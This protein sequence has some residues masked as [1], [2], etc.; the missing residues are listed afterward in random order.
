M[1]G[2]P[3]RLGPF[4]EGMNNED[5]PET[6]GDNQL[7]DVVNFELDN[8]GSLLSRPAYLVDVDTPVAGQ[9]VDAHGYYVRNDGVT[10]LVCTTDA[11]TWVYDITAKTWLE[12][13]AVKA[14]GFAQYDNKIV[15]ISELAAGGY[16]E[17]GVFTSTPTMP[18][19]SDIVFYQERFWAFGIRGTANQ[20]RVWFSNVTSAGTP[21]TSIW[22]WTTAS[23][24][25]EVNKGDGQWVTGLLA[26][27]NSLIIFRNR[28]TWRL[29][30]GGSPL[31]TG[32][33]DQLN[34]AIGTDNKD[35]FVTYESYYLTL[36]QGIL[37]QFINYQFYPLNTKRV[38]FQQ[39]TPD[40]SLRRTTALSVLA[41][42]AI[43]WY[44]GTTYV[45]SINTNTW[46]RWHSELHRPSLTLQIPPTSLAGD[47]RVGLAQA[48]LTTGPKGLLRIRDEVLAGTSGEQMTCSVRTKS[49]SLEEA[50]Q[51]KRLFYW[52]VEVKSSSGVE[53]IATP[54][55]LSTEGVT[56]DE[57]DLVTCDVLDLGNADNPLIIVPT[58]ESDVDFPTAAPVRTTVKLGQALSYLRLRFDIA[59]ECDGTSR[60]SQARI[61]SITPYT[62]IRGGVAEKVS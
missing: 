53:G 24:Y 27:V 51:Y 1:P 37:Y 28:S 59:L 48:G 12:I 14:S 43:V 4:T 16:W 60:T 2:T 56:C 41:H 31:L 44:Y 7:A 52:V 50:A 18:Q 40:A 38:K 21:P 10:F 35:T 29:T 62:R 61:Y 19:G 36:S 42:R 45:Y 20:T 25:F 22:D 39:S 33:L 26:D 5:E 8:D 15:L 23:D 58:Y 47:V 9:F 17:A 49:Y 11:K 13:W 30:F 3:H 54:S 32:S 57:M 46:S 55:A 34:P 6:I